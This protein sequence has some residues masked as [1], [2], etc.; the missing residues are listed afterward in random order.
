MALDKVNF[1]T[2]AAGERDLNSSDLD[3]G[4]LARLNRDF[5]VNVAEAT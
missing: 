5:Y 2:S 1:D 4:R 3:L